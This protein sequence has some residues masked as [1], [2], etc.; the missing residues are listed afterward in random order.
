MPDD[1][2]KQHMTAPRPERRDEAVLPLE[3][4]GLTLR[5]N[6]RRLLDD[7]SVM[8][9]GH[10]F[11]A[12]MGPNG[13]GK[14]LLLRV[15]ANLIP[16]DE[17]T[18]RWANRTPDRRRAPKLGFVFQK[19][20]TLRRSV[21]ANIRYALAA[22]GI[23]GADGQRRTEAVLDLAGLTTLARSPARVLS[24][25]EQQR[26]AIA[27][28]L[29]VE[30]ELLLL[31]EPTANLDPAATAAIETLLRGAAYGGT[32][33][34]LVTHDIGQARRLAETVVFMHGGRIT[35]TGAAATFFDAPTSE[36]AEAFL[37]GRLVL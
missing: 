15:L 23:R 26:L 4:L 32:K 33:I 35:E 30:P 2:A 14:S 29:A 36:A 34:V 28:A 1:G 19:P 12:L 16:P 22:C 21:R 5:R 13:A 27:R 37:S 3:G 18:V 17:G 8:F 31:D 24:G 7:I 11:C 9:D 20:V 6:G 25:G 10:D